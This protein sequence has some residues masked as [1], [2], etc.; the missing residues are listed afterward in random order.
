MA[1]TLAASLLLWVLLLLLAPARYSVLLKSSRW[2]SSCGWCASTSIDN[3]VGCMLLKP[4]YL[5]CLILLVAHT[6]V[7]VCASGA[8]YAF[9]CSRSTFFCL[10]VPWLHICLS[11]IYAFMLVPE[12]QTL[13]ILRAQSAYRIPLCL[14]LPLYA[15]SCCILLCL[16]VPQLHTLVPQLLTLVPQ[17]Q[18]WFRP[19]VS[20]FGHSEMALSMEWNNRYHFQN[21]PKMLKLSF[22]LIVLH[23]L[24]KFW[25]ISTFQPFGAVLGGFFSLEIANI[26]IHC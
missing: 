5:T 9:L 3:L 25:P 6:L 8:F 10:Y 20:N 22:E 11:C 14:Y 2:C 1:L 7:L 24:V 4:L 17:L 21:A 13:L 26:E 12:L 23:H 19:K 16:C 18:L 15:H